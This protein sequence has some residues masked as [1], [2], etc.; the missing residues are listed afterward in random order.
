MSVLVEGSAARL[1]GGLPALAERLDAIPGI[2]PTSAQVIVAEIGGDMS[3]FP[4]AAHL[5]SWAKLCPRPLQSG[6]KNTSGPNNGGNPW[7]R[8][9]LGEAAMAAARTDTFLGARYRRLVKR[10]GHNKALVAV[11]RSILVIIWYLINDPDATYQDLGADWHQRLTVPVRRTR[12][13]VRRLEALGH[14]VALAPN[15]AST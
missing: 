9:A 12:D 14:Q 15:A 5:V 3:I 7:M 1:P 8:G 6:G 4:T 10:G 11:A 13:L 2:G